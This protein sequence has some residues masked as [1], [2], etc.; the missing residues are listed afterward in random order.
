MKRSGK[1]DNVAE[2]APNNQANQPTQ[3]V[4]MRKVGCQ[5]WIVAGI[6]LVKNVH[7]SAV[8]RNQSSLLLMNRANVILPMFRYERAQ[9]E[10]NITCCKAMGSRSYSTKSEAVDSH[11]KLLERS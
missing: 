6:E 7:E 11:T 2:T 4:L 9:W 8:E 3:T 1:E 10:G 5:I